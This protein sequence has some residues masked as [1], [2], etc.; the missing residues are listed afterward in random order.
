LLE[1]RK[2][3]LSKGESETNPGRDRTK[4]C[5]RARGSNLLP[6]NLA[7]PCPEAEGWALARNSTGLEIQA[8]QFGLGK[9]EGATFSFDCPC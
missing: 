6:R 8:L 3:L 5:A 1:R 9:K 7:A 2:K 4:T